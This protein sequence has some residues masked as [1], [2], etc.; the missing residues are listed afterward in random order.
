TGVPNRKPPGQTPRGA[1]P[2]G[3]GGRCE[4]EPIEE[5][6]E[7]RSPFRAIGAAGQAA[8]VAVQLDVR[9]VQH[10]RRPA[11]H[12]VGGQRGREQDLRTRPDVKHPGADLR[13]RRG[14]R[15]FRSVSNVSVRSA[16][17]VVGTPPRSKYHRRPSWD[18][19]RAG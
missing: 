13:E 9:C 12:V 8:E 16:V 7:G 3:T 11:W 4:R 17:I 15:W 2:A 10:R 19:G 18:R 6:P 5:C 1:S 14:S